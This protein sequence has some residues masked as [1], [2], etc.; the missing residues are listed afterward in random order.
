MKVTMSAYIYVGEREGVCV[1]QQDGKVMLTL[2]VI[3]VCNAAETR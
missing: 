3:S 1:Y 2:A